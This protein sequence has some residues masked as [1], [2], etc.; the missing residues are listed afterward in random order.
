MSNKR[1]YYEVLE[2]SRSATEDEIKKAYRQKALKHHPDQNPDNPESESLFKEAAEAYEVLSD[3]TKRQRYNQFGHAGLDRNSMHDFS[4]MRTDDIFSVFRDIFGGGFG[5]FGGGGRG[6]DAKAFVTISLKEAATGVEKQAT[7]QYASYCKKCKGIGGTGKICHV[8]S[9]NGKVRQNN[10]P[11][12]V[13]SVCPNCLGKTIKVDKAC[14]SCNGDG[15]TTTSGTI[16]FQIPPGINDGEVLSFGGHGHANKPSLPR[17]N[18]HIQVRVLP[19][20]TIQRDG[21]HLVSKK[22]LSF[23]DVCLGTNFNIETIYGEVIGLSVPKGTQIGQVFR[24]PGHG[25]PS[26]HGKGDMYVQIEVEV[27]SS[28]SPK[29]VEALQEF[30]RLTR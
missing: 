28:L 13:V 22:T 16:S 25:M 14:S 17:G 27:P 29:A 5:G 9:G 2:V 10:G 12:S 26:S 3:N 4:H 6:A 18:L 24:L 30:D 11:F 20:E 7:Y 19:H 15:N 8:C 1:D 23:A 21:Q